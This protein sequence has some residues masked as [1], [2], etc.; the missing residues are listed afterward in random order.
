[1]VEIYTQLNSCTFSI[2][3]SFISG[4]RCTWVFLPIAIFYLAF[5]KH[6]FISKKV[7]VFTIFILCVGLLSLSQTQEVTKQIDSSNYDLTQS[8]TGN[9][10]TSL[11]IIIELCKSAIYTTEQNPIIGLGYNGRETL[12]EKWAH[13]NLMNAQVI[14]NYFDSQ[15]I[16]IYIFIR[17]KCPLYYLTCCTSYYFYYSSKYLYKKPSCYKLTST[18]TDQPLFYY[19]SDHDDMLLFDLS[20]IPS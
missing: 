18:E 11:G 8:Q 9:E 13:E 14:K 19:Q 7:F 10:Y 1:M 4:T 6:Q 15:L 12:I 20:N 17:I 16:I 3:I 2:Y 5:S